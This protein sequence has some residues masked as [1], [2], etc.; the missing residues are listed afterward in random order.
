[1]AKRQQEKYQFYGFVLPKPFLSETEKSM[2]ITRNHQKVILES[3]DI[4]TWNMGYCVPGEYQY[5][6]NNTFLL[7]VDT[8]PASSLAK[9]YFDDQI[10]DVELGDIIPAI[11][12]PQTNPDLKTATLGL[13][14]SEKE[15]VR[16]ETLCPPSEV[17]SDML[18]D[19]YTI[20]YNSIKLR[21]IG[22]LSQTRGLAEFLKDFLG[23]GFETTHDTAVLTLHCS[24]LCAFGT[25]QPDATWYHKEKYICDSALVGGLALPDDQG[26]GQTVAK[27][28]LTGDA[29]EDKI[30][31]NGQSQA[32]AAMLLLATK[33]GIVAINDNQKFNKAIIFGFVRTIA[34]KNIIPYK[35]VLDFFGKQSQIYRS[36]DEMAVC[37]YVAATKFILENPEQNLILF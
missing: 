9:D 34:K 3:E 24:N 16:I 31:L 21:S 13:Q 30:V 8:V 15:K 20:L 29:G 22:E 36:K 10:K 12:M 19:T 26:N 37:D 11:A 32:I 1:M 23:S 14:V 18:M 27:M 33:L 25:S 35:L 17:S 7:C 28:V 5:V 6:N 4:T 2:Y